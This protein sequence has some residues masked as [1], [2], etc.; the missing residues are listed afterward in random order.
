MLP[1]LEIMARLRDKTNGCEWDKAQTFTSIAPYTIEEAYE[2]ADA[3]ERNDLA[4]LKDE[5]GDLLFQ[6]VFHARMAEEMGAFDFTDVEAAICNKMERRHPH[7]FGDAMQ[8]PGWENLKAQERD[9]KGSNSAL[10]GV[11]LALPGLVRAQKIQKRASKVGF[12]WE[13]IGPVRDKL[14]E[15]IKELDAASSHDEIEDEMGDVLFAA[16]N[17]ARHHGV[18]AEKALKRATKK[19]ENRFQIVEELAGKSLTNRNSSELEQLWERA[20]KQQSEIK[21][22]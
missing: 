17:L 20:K 15:E 8:S 4:D 5:L 2:V 10:D 1:I 18:D 16:V 21:A 11:A 3:I 19:F 7:I 13:D 12:D 6:V 22:N 14:N 9:E